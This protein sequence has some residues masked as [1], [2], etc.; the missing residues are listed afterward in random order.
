MILSRPRVGRSQTREVGGKERS[1]WITKRLPMSNAFRKGI[2]ERT[3]M[4]FAYCLGRRKMIEK[5][6][7]KGKKR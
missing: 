6:T 5:V 4:G 1:A 3:I 7:R 2:A